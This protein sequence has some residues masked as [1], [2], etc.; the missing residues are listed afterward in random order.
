MSFLLS[1]EAGAGRNRPLPFTLGEDAMR[2][3]ELARESETPG[4]LL[5]HEPN[6]ASGQLACAGCRGRS[7]LTANLAGRYN[8]VKRVAR[9]G[10]VDGCDN[11]SNHLG[12]KEISLLM[13]GRREIPPPGTRMVRSHRLAVDLPPRT[14]LRYR[15]SPRVPPA[16]ELAATPR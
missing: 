14:G 4:S 5:G 9:K 2:T 12:V 11:Q 8:A 6:A 10:G 7:K 13:A 15:A 3:Q 16:G 1:I